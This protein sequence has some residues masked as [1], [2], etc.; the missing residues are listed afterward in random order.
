[1]GKWLRLQKSDAPLHGMQ[2]KTNDSKNEHK[3]FSLVGEGEKDAVW[4]LEVV[5]AISSST[6]G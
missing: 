2:L 6:Q 4:Q 1:M 3:A 5:P